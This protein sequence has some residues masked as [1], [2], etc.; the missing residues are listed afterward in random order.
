MPECRLEK[1]TIHL[2]FNPNF[3]PNSK[4]TDWILIGESNRLEC[5]LRGNGELRYVVQIAV[6]ND[7]CQTKIVN[8]N[9]LPL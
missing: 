6:F 2:Q 5:R 3:L 7:P 9:I 1:I 4:F 8:K